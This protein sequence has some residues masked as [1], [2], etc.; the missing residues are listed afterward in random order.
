[1]RGRLALL[2]AVTG[3]L[4]LPSAPTA[5]PTAAAS[6]RTSAI[7]AAIEFED[8]GTSYYQDQCKDVEECEVPGDDEFTV[9]VLGDLHMDPRKMEDYYTGRDHLKPIIEDATKRGVPTMLV[10]L[11]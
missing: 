9:C 4:L 3:A 1:M 2:P 6:S 10:S 8:Q 7:T 11:G 5:R